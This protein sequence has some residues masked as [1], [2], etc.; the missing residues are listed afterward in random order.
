VTESI[1]WPQSV[2]SHPTVTHSIA[3]PPFRQHREL[4]LPPTSLI[5][6]AIGGWPATEHACSRP[7]ALTSPARLP[8]SP[9]PPLSRLLPNVL[10]HLPRRYPLMGEVGRGRR[11]LRRRFQRRRRGQRRL[12]FR[13]PTPTP[14]PF[15]SRLRDRGQSSLRRFSG[16]PTLAILTIAPQPRIARGRYDY[17]GTEGAERWD[18]CY[19]REFADSRSSLRSR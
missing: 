2:A 11:R 4:P 9:P 16:F 14:A 18:R 12:S 6:L 17:R 15:L 5:A 10:Q 13:P 8:P 19:R 7:A 1:D 3:P